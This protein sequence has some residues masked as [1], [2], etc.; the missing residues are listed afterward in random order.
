MD[1]FDARFGGACLISPKQEFG[2]AMGMVVNIKG[3]FAH[4]R[5]R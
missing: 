5:F 3:G 1:G 2:H 4:Q